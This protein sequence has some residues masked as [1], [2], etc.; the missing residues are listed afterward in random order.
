MAYTP[1]PANNL[2]SSAALAHLQT[3]YYEKTALSILRTKFRFNEIAEPFSLP[4]GVGK[5]L[6]LYR[7][8]NLPSNTTSKSP[9]G[10][11]G[12]SINLPASK[13]V[14][15]TVA[16]YT[17]YI[18]IS[19]FLVA[20]ANDQIMQNASDSLGYRAGLTLDILTR[21]IIDNE[22]SSM[23]LSLLGATFKVA[24]LRNGWAQLQGV[25]V[26]PRSDGYYRV[27][28]HPYVAFDILNDPSVVGLADTYK[29]TDPTKA[30]LISLPD[31][32][33]V[34]VAGTCKVVVS[35]NVAQISGTPNK[36][37]V[38]IFGKEA[39]GCADLSGMGPS[40]VVDP[41]KEKFKIK[42]W[43]NSGDNA[44]PADPEGVIGGFVSYNFY[45]GCAMLEGPAGIG[46]QYRA[47]TWDAPSS[48]VS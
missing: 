14:Q 1:V 21:T 36:W 10:S 31:R 11:V 26:E 28:I 33:E 22:A 17:D 15:I 48:I 16:Q 41:N 7:Y 12:T 8:T 42:M 38:Y 34:C 18:T 32:G 40:K 6:Q 44:G 47:R 46:G 30:G 35:T 24:D 37:R 4:K 13:T 25:N 9:E 43:K 3:I 19:D 29:Y 27:Y 45:Y 2:T 5:T 23:N 20:T 39:V